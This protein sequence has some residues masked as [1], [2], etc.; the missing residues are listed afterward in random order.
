MAEIKIVYGPAGCGKTYKAVEDFYESSKLCDPLFPEKNSFLIVPEQQTVEIER[1]FFE[2]DTSG[3]IGSE[4]ISFARLVNRIVSEADRSSG[5]PITPS[6]RA[7]LLVKVLSGIEE[8]LTFFKS[9]AGK[10]SAVARL[11]STV[12][13]LKKY[14][15]TPK[16]LSEAAEN[17]RNK[18]PED[19]L[20][21]KKLDE[22]ALILEKYSEETEGYADG[23]AVADEAADIILG[24][25]SCAES[26]SFFFDGFSGFTDVELG[27]IKA[28]SLRASDL[29]FYVFKDDENP[30]FSIPNRTYDTLKKMFPESIDV[31]MDGSLREKTRFSG[32]EMLYI[33]SKK[34]PEKPKNVYM[35]SE[36]EKSA[37]EVWGAVD[38]YY[39][40]ECCA[41]RIRE[42]VSEEGSDITYS[43]IA[44]AVPS[45]QDS[46]HI[47]DAVFREFGIP[48]F[49][50]ARTEF[51]GHVI[52]RFIDAFL[53][54]VSEDRFI[55]NMLLLLKTGLYRKEVYSTDDTDLL[56]NAMLLYA[57]DKKQSLESFGRFVSG[58]EN[59]HKDVEKPG[60]LLL[61]REI[62]DLFKGE[63][64]YSERAKKCLS[65]D[66]VLDLIYDFAERSGIKSANASGAKDVGGVRNDRD[67]I[68]VRNAFIDLLSE[69]SETMGA[70]NRP[71]G[72]AL[73]R[74]TDDV[75]MS[76]AASINA[77]AIPYSG[78]FVQIGDL[79][80]SSYINKKVMMAIGCNEGSFPG[81]V[82][83]SSFIGDDER[84]AIL[85]AGGNTA[86]NSSDRALLSQYNVYKV[87]TCPRELLYLSYALTDGKGGELS[88]ASAI[89]TVMNMFKGLK[90]RT[91][92]PAGS[93]SAAVPVLLDPDGVSLD[94]DLVKKILGIDKTY[95]V[96]PS[97]LDSSIANC[98][99]KFYLEKLL[100][101]SDRGQGDLTFDITGSFVHY[102]FEYSI[103]KAIREDKVFSDD[104]KLWENYVKEAKAEYFKDNEAAERLVENSG[105]NSIFVELSEGSAL[106]DLNNMA[107]LTDPTATGVPVLLEFSF[108]KD[109]SSVPAFETEVD[110]IKA[111]FKGTIDRIDAGTDGD[112]IILTLT[113]YKGGSYTADGIKKGEKLQLPLYALALL[114]GAAKKTVL[115][116]LNDKGICGNSFEVENLRYYI[117]ADQSD[118]REKSHVFSSFSVKDDPGML[119]AAEGETPSAETLIRE[120]VRAM[121]GGQ[122]GI[123]EKEISNCKYCSYSSIC[124]I[125]CR[126]EDKK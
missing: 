117:Y 16:M 64:G 71:R 44:V 31:P 17:S 30:V 65:V 27:I 7:M 50:D 67:F 124:K 35:V 41:K 98:P 75:I 81:A 114:S 53:K 9:I 68:K 10:P 60:Y 14:K 21:P 22:L 120:R 36:D 79:E 19:A 70:V 84:E 66:A 45:V 89:L 99:F 47:I 125:K 111:V 116:V 83:D 121:V 96:S 115:K 24:G 107:R 23:V 126:E 40:I 28:L 8:K 43:D 62:F 80:R 69:C 118:S 57:C 26:A 63:G 54:M 122:Y 11:E 106:R 90:I 93:L 59:N 94:Q 102:I 12:S 34:F 18:R 91:Y 6:V 72:K 82:P 37:I 13:E 108:G 105:R 61:A 52:V 123:P 97:S 87:L 86:Y 29:T 76:A 119:D 15:V 73:V 48:C 32:S 104:P 39:E 78:D 58:E 100:R 113:D 109:G 38:A 25:D 112:T 4:V 20:T 3:L 77:A 103:A 46:E 92:A 74:F 110:G 88:P 51:S 42:L 33:L 56:E 101:L 85:D 55:D 1:I 49:I 2:N 5:K 95:Y